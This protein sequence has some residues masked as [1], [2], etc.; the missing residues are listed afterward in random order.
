MVGTD[1]RM[2]NFPGSD[3]VVRA[4]L[5]RRLHFQNQPEDGHVL[6]MTEA[7]KAIGTVFI[8]PVTAGYQFNRGAGTSKFF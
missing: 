8:R 5:C 1:V 4:Y 6:I 2:R 7:I 3:M